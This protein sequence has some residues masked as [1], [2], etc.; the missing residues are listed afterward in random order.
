VKPTPRLD[1]LR[2]MREAEYERHRHPVPVKPSR[3]P[4]SVTLPQIREAVAVV[5][6]KVAAKP[7]KVKKR[8]PK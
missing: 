7:R 4:T 8:K 1:A 2:A 3:P 6:A 5:A